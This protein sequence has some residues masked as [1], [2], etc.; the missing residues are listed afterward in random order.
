[1]RRFAR[2]KIVRVITSDRVAARSESGF[3]AAREMARQAARL[4]GRFSEAPFPATGDRAR[5]A[6]TG[7][8]RPARAGYG[9]SR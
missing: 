6:G 2:R 8:R 7:S 4:E 9:F 3:H 1:M 5:D